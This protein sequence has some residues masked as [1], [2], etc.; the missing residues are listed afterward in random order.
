MFSFIQRRSAIA[1]LLSIFVCC[2]SAVAKVEA[3]KGKR[4]TLGPQHGPW[5][6]MAAALRDVPEERRTAGGMSAWEAAD[7]LVYELRMQGI[8]A[9]TYLQDLQMGELKESSGK[10]AEHDKRKY[11]ARHEAIAVLAGSFPSPDD[12]LAQRVLSYLKNDFHPK[13]LNDSSNGGILPRL[14]SRKAPLGRAHMTTNPLMPDSEVKRRTVDP[15]V[16]KLNAG[17]EYSLMNN[18]G[19]YSLKIATFRGSSIVQVGNSVNEKAARHFDKVFGSNLDESGVKA[20]ELTQALRSARKFGY[21]EDFEAYVFHDRFESFV[22]VGS[23]NSEQDPRL[24]A[25][26]KRFRARE[27]QQDGNVVTIAEVFTIPRRI[28]AGSVPEKFWLFDTVPTLV[29]VP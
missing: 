16:Q 22:T 11:I 7:Q 2:S 25:L 12:P 3:V 13:F 18:K 9:Y 23:F 8:P 14:A 20:W 10:A 15:V 5:M 4:Y 27:Q 19:K 6:I 28:P 17:E 1:A 26:A 21:D 29:R 24:I